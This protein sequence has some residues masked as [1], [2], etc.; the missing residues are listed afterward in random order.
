MSLTNLFKLQVKKRTEKIVPVETDL[1]QAIQSRLQNTGVASPEASSGSD[2]DGSPL[3][4]TARIS[5]VIKKLTQPI[6]YRTKEYPMDEERQKTGGIIS[7]RDFLKVSG[8]TAA[9]SAA[10]SAVRRP[11][12]QSLEEVSPE[13]RLAA[14][15]EQIFRSICRPNCF[16]YCSLNVHVRDGKI[17]KTSRADAVDPKY[18]RICLRGLTHAQRTYNPDRIKYPMKRAGERGEDKWERISWDEAITTITDKW[19]SIQTEH[20]KQAVSFYAASGSITLYQG[21]LPGITAR[22]RN[23]IEATAISS[24]VDAAIALG[25]GRT[26]GGTL[27][28]EESDAK[29]AKTVIAWGCNLTEAM[30]Q[31]WHFFA[32]AMEAGVKMVVVDPVFTILASKADEFIQIRPASDTAL[33]LSLMQVIIS[34]NLHNVEF[35]QAHTV[36]PF[37]VREDTKVFLRMSDL[38]VAPTDG[39][40]GADGKPTKLDPMAVWDEAT[41]SAVAVG[42]IDKP[43]IEGSYDIKGIKVRTAFDLL[44][45]EVSKYTPEEASKLTEIAPETIRHLAHVCADGPVYHLIGFGPQAYDNGVHTAHATAAL[46]AL[47]GNI[48]YPGASLGVDWSFHPGTNFAFSFPNMTFGPSI[49]NLVYRKVIQTGLYQGKPFPIKSMYVYS[50][51]P[52]N[53]AANTKE[54]TENLL[55]TLDMVVV[56]DMV[57]T[58]TARYA[59]IVLPVADWFETEEICN[60]GQ[61]HYIKFSEKAIE[62]L[63]ESK[64]DADITRLLAEK[65]GMGEFFTKTDREMMAEALDTEYSKSLGITVENLIEKKAIRYY[66]DPFIAYEGNIFP[67]PTGRI[68][69][70]VENPAPRLP[71]DEAMDL[72]RER[73]PRFFPPTEA[74]P[75]N[76]LHDKYPL[77]LLSERPKFRVHSQWFGNSWLRELDP[78]PIIKINHQDASARNIKNGDYVEV[79]NDRGHAVVKAVLSQGIKPGVLV[80]PKGWQRKQYIAGDLSELTSSAF[81]PVGVNSSFMD[82]LAEVRKWNGEV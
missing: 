50:G 55:P 80:F 13:M 34:E 60:S 1:W 76:P 68:E 26:V 58:D 12:L 17:V 32:E 63:Y 8:A 29:N 35:L 22:L 44:K 33:T 38:G 3:L 56:A 79:F 73:L 69:F 5:Q 19:K 37:L 16:A 24:D 54:W 57:F 41:K 66:K 72:D 75:E 25:L 64:S 36:A 77:V 27:I 59:D 20:G 45:E 74:W 70:Y 47:T 78:E 14:A 23:L 28:S 40:A 9:A 31:T 46:V 39:P 10:I 42:T 82:E 6:S 81:D 43:A 48:G 61:D 65:M 11:V 53:T 18:N 15:D 52:A 30:P 4:N 21:M 49:S 71:S 62:P 2:R 51:N 7:R 67:T